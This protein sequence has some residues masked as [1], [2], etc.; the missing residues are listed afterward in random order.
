MWIRNIIEA[1]FSLGLF[2][3]AALFIPQIIQL[4]RV[5]DARGLSLL[6]FG[7]FAFIQLFIVLHGLIH[8]DYLLLIGCLISLLMCCI[9][10]FLIIFYRLKRSDKISKVKLGNE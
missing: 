5:K 7:G 3:N 2:I 9:I 10:S 4:L 6:T 1:G 8:K